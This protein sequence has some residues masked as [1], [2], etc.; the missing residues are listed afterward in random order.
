LYFEFVSYACL[1][2]C[3]RKRYLLALDLVGEARV[4]DVE[5]KVEARAELA[6]NRSSRVRAGTTTN[7]GGGGVRGRAASTSSTAGHDAGVGTARGS[8]RAGGHVTE[9]VLGNSRSHA[10]EGQDGGGGD[11]GEGRHFDFVWWWWWLI[12]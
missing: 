6:V 7:S 2:I 3:C 11:G 10:R 5:R 1:S 12:S 9:V 4:V 8:R